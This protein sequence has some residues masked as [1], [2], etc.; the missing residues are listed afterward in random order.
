MLSSKAINLV[1]HIV[2]MDINKGFKKRF[3][4]CKTGFNV[5]FS[6]HINFLLFICIVLLNFIRTFNIFS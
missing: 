3:F 6:S 5:F 1:V 2:R 4:S